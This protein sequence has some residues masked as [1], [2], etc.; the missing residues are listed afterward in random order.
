MHA[1]VGISSLTKA[2]I[3]E[4]DPLDQKSQV[5]AF[6]NTD[7]GLKVQCWQ[8]GDL[9]PNDVVTP[10]NGLNGNV[11]RT[12]LAGNIAITL[13]SF[14]PSVTIFSFGVDEVHENAVDFRAKPK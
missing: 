10:A 9:L 13:F 11:R 4:E 1:P 8:I 7:D 3:D 12:N 14:A 6:V 5:T 2:R